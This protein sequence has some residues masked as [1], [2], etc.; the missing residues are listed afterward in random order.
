MENKKTG[1]SPVFFLLF[2]VFCFAMLLIWLLKQ[3]VV[4]VDGVF[5]AESDYSCLHVF[6]DFFTFEDDVCDAVCDDL[7]I[8][9]LHAA[10]G[11]GRCAD[12]KTAG[13]KG[14]FGVAG[15]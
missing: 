4:G 13:D 6:N 11:D 2:S 15:D 7:H 9:F 1:L 14:F 8:L 12:A 5:V 10:S 3:N